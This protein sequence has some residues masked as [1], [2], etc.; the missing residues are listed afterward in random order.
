MRIAEVFASIQGEGLLAG[1]PSLFLRTSGCN[2]RC[3]WCDTEYTSWQPEGEDWTVARLAEWAAGQP[4]YR[5]AVLTGGEPLLQPELPALAAELKRLGLHITVE[6][7]G[8]VMAD[9]DCDLMSVSPKL[10]NSTPWEREAGRWA[11]THERLRLQPAVLAAL[12]DRYQCQWKFVIDNAPDL[13]EVRQ[14]SADLHLPAGRVLLMPQGRT[15]EEVRARAVWVVEECQR[16]GY[17]YCPRLHLDLFG[18][19]RGV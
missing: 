11:P 13:A 14:L 1:V 3:H 7:A 19:R 15:P 5:H 12:R 10:A 2:L 6:T 18:A 16:Y 8:T 4:Q 17:R 9:L